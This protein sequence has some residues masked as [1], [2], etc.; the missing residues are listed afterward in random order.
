[1]RQYFDDGSIKER[2][3]KMTEMLPAG[4]AG[5]FSFSEIVK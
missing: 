5:L 4:N 2:F 3:G 1:M